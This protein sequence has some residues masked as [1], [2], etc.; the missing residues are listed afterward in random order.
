MHEGHQRLRLLGLPVF[1]TIGDLAAQLHIDPG[2]LTILTRY[3]ERFYRTY[4]I[5]KRTGGWRQISQPSR[6]LKG[7]Q[8]WIL[9]N[10]IDKLSPSP[11]ATAY[12]P[13]KRLSDNVTPHSGNRYF[14]SVNLEEFFPSIPR[15]RIQ[16]LFELIGYE[17]HTAALMSSLCTFFRSLPQGGVT[18][19]ALSNLVA[20]QMDRRISGL[21]SRRNIVF[22]RYADDMTFSSNNRVALIRA[23]PSIK[24]IL[25]SE[26]FRINEPKTRFLGPRIQCRITGLVKDSS[27]PRFGI[28]RKKKTRMRAIMHNLIT[29]KRRDP[30][31]P[32]Q[33]AIQGWLNF[34][35]GVDEKSHSQMSKYWNQLRNKYFTIHRTT[36]SSV[37]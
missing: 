21:V 3:G 37:P 33:E 23:L 20:L 14:L 4:R 11:H 36:G 16:R 10:I 5:P 19:P 34:L 9:R 2:R 29:G 30:D 31:Y 15:R 7:I 26:G 27:E 1:E 8:A 32:S 22:T 18:S 13:R 28:G 25:E 6:E 24:H 17:R 12:L 35:K